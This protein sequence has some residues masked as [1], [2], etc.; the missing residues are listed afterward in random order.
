MARR[1]RNFSY[2]LSPLLAQDAVAFLERMKRKA[3]HTRR[4]SAED[5]P[6]RS[7]VKTLTEIEG[8]IEEF[9]IEKGVWISTD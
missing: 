5:P 1:A 4:F 3:E 2:Q 6:Y 9:L 7:S 8:D